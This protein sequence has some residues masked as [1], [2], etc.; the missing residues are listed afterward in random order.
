MSTS[1][2]NN[3]TTTYST[4]TPSNGNDAVTG[5]DNRCVTGNLQGNRIRDRKRG[6]RGR[7]RTST[8]FK[9]ESKEMNGNVFNTYADQIEKG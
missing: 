9:G 1:N 6:G 5:H 3:K 7:G 8:Y 4:R 2:T